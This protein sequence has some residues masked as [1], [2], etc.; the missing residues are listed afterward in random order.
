MYPLLETI[1][2]KDG[3]F[4]H[5]AWHQKRYKDA[6]QRFFGISPN[7]ELLHN[8][9]LPAA[10]KNGIFKLRISYNQQ[11]KKVEY[12][13]YTLKRIRTLKIVEDNTIDYSLK[14]ANRDRL[15]QLYQLRGRCDDIL[16]VKN[17][18]ITDSSYTNIVFFDGE[19]WVTP[20]T[21]LLRGTARERL[22][23]SGAIV[24]RPV[25]VEDLPQFK[26]FKLINAFRALDSITASEIKNILI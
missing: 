1:C 26:S 11:A 21:P 23:S 2:I 22:L 18:Q 25:R 3:I 16:I 20:A 12:E 14:F 8:I 15:K 5:P 7:T 6:Y 24:E 4:Q 17:G 10:C 13:P 9:V 19:Q